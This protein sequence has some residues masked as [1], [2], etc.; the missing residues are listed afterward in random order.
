MT[1]QVLSNHIRILALHLNRLLVV[2]GHLFR[3]GHGVVFMG[4]KDGLSAGLLGDTD[5]HVSLESE[6][7]VG[8]TLHGDVDPVV[9]DQAAYGT[10]VG[11]DTVWKQGLF[12]HGLEP[13]DVRE[14]HAAD[15][16]SWS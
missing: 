12:R 8:Q 7:P 6:R 11:H 1:Y 4:G 14:Y 16:A 5:R 2:V 15:G 3:I 10:L 9:G 13:L